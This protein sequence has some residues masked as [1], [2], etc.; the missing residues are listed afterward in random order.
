MVSVPCG[1]CSGRGYH[2]VRNPGFPGAFADRMPRVKQRCMKC[3]GRRTVLLQTPPRALK[4]S[5]ARFAEL[6]AARG[7]RVDPDF[8][9][10]PD[11]WTEI[12]SALVDSIAGL[13]PYDELSVD[14]FDEDLDL[15]VTVPKASRPHGY[16][17]QTWLTKGRLKKKARE[18]RDVIKDLGWSYKVDE[19]GDIRL[20]RRED[21]FNE[22]DASDL[23]GEI[24]SLFRLVFRA[25]PSD[26]SQTVF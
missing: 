4:T 7:L 19:D 25:E 17:A 20:R 12:R 10:T 21:V 3:G 26:V 15:Y 2:M 5:N 13:E 8:V 6:L 24:V 1:S 11:K 22:D 9:K 16:R 14:A 18:A 23:A